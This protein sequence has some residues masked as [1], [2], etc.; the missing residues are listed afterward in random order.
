MILVALIGLL[1]TLAAGA[2]WLVRTLRTELA[3]LRTDAAAQLAERSAESDRRVGELAASVD[4]RLEG[5]DGRL[6]ATQRASGQTATQI[7][8]K[9]GKLDGTAAQ[10]LA[11]ANDL[12]KLEQVLRPPKARGGFGELLLENLLRDRLP[13][14]AYTMQHGFSSGERVDAVV[15]VGQLIPVDSKFP[16]DNFQRMTLAQ[17]DDERQLCAKAFARD[18]KSKIDD[19]ASKYI[20]P[21]E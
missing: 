7:V 21:D 16:L 13:A 1:L 20:R 15:R 3:S 9:L 6:L 4:R 11:R 19:I 17:S 10:M 12:A 14:T 18:V 8:E 2:A 5:I